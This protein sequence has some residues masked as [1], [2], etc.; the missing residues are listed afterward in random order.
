MNDD[1]FRKVQAQFASM[2]A[3][4]AAGLVDD[5]DE[6]DPD[7]TAP[8][9]SLAALEAAVA[10]RA[11]ATLAR[12]GRAEKLVVTTATAA[13]AA[14]AAAPSWQRQSRLPGGTM[15]LSTLGRNQLAG[16]VAGSLGL[17][18]LPQ[19]A[20]SSTGSPS[21]LVCPIDGSGS[22][23]SAGVPLVPTKVTSSATLAA[24]AWSASSSGSDHGL[25]AA[26]W[27][28]S[29]KG[30]ATEYAVHVW[31][32][33]RVAPGSSSGAAPLRAQ[34]LCRFIGREAVKSLCWSDGRLAVCSP[35]AIRLL[36]IDQSSSDASTAAGTRS[37]LIDASLADLLPCASSKWS[38]CH[39]AQDGGVLVGMSRSDVVFFV[40]DAAF[41]REAAASDSPDRPQPRRFSVDR[42]EMTWSSEQELGSAGCGELRGLQVLPPPATCSSLQGGSSNGRVLAQLVVTADPALV[43]AEPAQISVASTPSPSAGASLSSSS[44]LLSELSDPPSGSG[45]AGLIS[46]VASGPIDL[47]GKL[48]SGADGAAAAVRLGGGGEDGEEGPSIPAFLMLGSAEAEEAAATQSFTALL[49]ENGA[50]G[51]GSSAAGTKLSSARVVTLLA[52]GEEDSASSEGLPTIRVGS[53]LALPGLGPYI[54]DLL[55]C[56]EASRTVFVGSSHDESCQLQALA[57]APLEKDADEDADEDV[58]LRRLA[59]STLDVSQQLHPDASPDSSSAKQDRVKGVSCFSLPSS[60]GGRGFLVLTAKRASARDSQEAIKEATANAIVRGGLGGGGIGVGATGAGLPALAL[61]SAAVAQY[62]TVFLSFVA[63]AD[64]EKMLETDAAAEAAAAVVHRRVRSPSPTS[65]LGLPSSPL[66]EDGADS[67]LLPGGGGGVGGGSSLFTL[68]V[69]LADAQAKLLVQPQQQQQQQQE[70]QQEVQRHAAD[71]SA[72]GQWSTGD[73]A[74]WLMSPGPAGP[75]CAAPIAAAAERASI[76]GAALLELHAL[77]TATAGADAA[78]S[79]GL[80]MEILQQEMGVSRVGERLRVF[81]KLRTALQ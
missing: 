7:D 22:L 41:W 79:R 10:A 68:P 52:S 18:A 6:Q 34:L 27:S 44:L 38:E 25:L 65:S 26:A 64:S 57:V 11:E 74:Q 50:G 58:E 23:S 77:W 69:P 37:E 42:R 13:V 16:C 39:F 80:A 19:P 67:L 17:A 9:P 75:G 54:P 30:P 2:F 36:S 49:N 21:I 33:Y 28:D 3:D 14:A 62:S 29:A 32:V 73:V 56:D 12:T 40:C 51:V 76:D 5:D 70:Q 59:E 48:G 60:D 53:A 1:A 4:S 31:R 66:S 72:V 55:A 63:R 78:S 61:S 8:M 20:P 35:S 43:I 47:T 46:E 24:V 15:T 71:A 45:A 81:Q